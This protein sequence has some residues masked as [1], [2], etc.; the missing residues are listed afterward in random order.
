ME[1]IPL[2]SEHE[3]E[4]VDLLKESIEQDLLTNPETK[5]KKDF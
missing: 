5:N 2:K 4:P 1:R 3:T